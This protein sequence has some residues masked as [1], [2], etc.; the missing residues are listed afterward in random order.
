MILLIEV[1]HFGNSMLIFKPK[2]IRRFEKKKLFDDCVRKYQSLE[3][4][5]LKWDTIKCEIR[6]ATIKNGTDKGKGIE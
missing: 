3:N 2:K 4:K 6:D 1:Q 5:N